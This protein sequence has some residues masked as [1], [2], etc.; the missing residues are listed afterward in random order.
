MKTKIEKNYLYD[1]LGFPVMLDKVEMVEID[2]DWHPKIDVKK[3]ADEVIAKLAVQQDR[4]TGNQIKFIRSYYSMPLREFGE[5]VV[6]ETHAAVDKWE[7]KKDLPTN[8]NANTEHELRLYII[9]TLFAKPESSKSFYEL[10]L[11][12][13]NFFKAN[14]NKVKRGAAINLKENII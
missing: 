13:K 7:K 12:T 2:G 3:V 10:Y 8:M 5:K 9:E 14:S 11:E 4:L 1:G 6:H